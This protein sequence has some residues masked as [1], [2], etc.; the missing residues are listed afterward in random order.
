MFSPEEIMQVETQG[1]MSTEFINVPDDE[2]LAVIDDV[3]IRTPQESVILDIFWQLD[4]ADGKLAELT[5]RDKNIVRQSIF[6]DMLESG[7]FDMG[8]GKNVYLGKLR[9]ALNQNTGAWSPRMLLGQAARIRTAQRIF[10]DKT[11]VD[12]KSVAPAA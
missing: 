4:D 5:G 1:S 12:V 2:Y 7:G 11:F 9:E 10:E 6:L 8:K 3:K